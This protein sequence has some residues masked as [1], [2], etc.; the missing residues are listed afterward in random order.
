[1]ARTSRS[2]PAELSPGWP[3]RES[4][5]PIAEVARRFAL[6]IEAKRGTRSLRSIALAT[7]MN[8]SILVNILAGRTWPDLATIARIER[9][10]E[11]DVWPGFEPED[12]RA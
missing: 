10:L 2:T 6:N 4:P 1:M 11:T 3:D 12:G 7:G 9:A 5:D 8:H